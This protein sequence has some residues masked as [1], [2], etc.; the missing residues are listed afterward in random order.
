MASPD[1]GTSPIPG[2][3][4]LGV[5]AM[6]GLTAL[7][8]IGLVASLIFRAGAATAWVLILLFAGSLVGLVFQI[9]TRAHYLERVRT[10]D[11]IV[12]EPW[13]GGDVP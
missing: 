13:T 12:R 6:L 11:V 3:N 4:S 5:N 7:S 10:G 1:R 2:E 8:G 9:R